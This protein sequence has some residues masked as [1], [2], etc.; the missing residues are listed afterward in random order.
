M[1]FEVSPHEEQPHGDLRRLRGEDREH[2]RPRV[3]EPLRA[4]EQLQ[5]PWPRGAELPSSHDI[6]KKDITYYSIIYHIYSIILYY[7]ILDLTSIPLSPYILSRLE[8]GLKSRL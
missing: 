6:D 8:H 1:T 2:R 5:G 4:G 7:S 3:T